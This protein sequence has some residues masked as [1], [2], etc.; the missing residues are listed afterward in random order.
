MNKSEALALLYSKKNIRLTASNW[1]EDEFIT[2]I[3]GVV[4]SLDGKAY[5]IMTAEEDEFIEWVEPI[6]V[7]TLKREEALQALFGGKRIKALEWDDS[8]NLILKDGQIVINDTE[9]FN[10]MT[11]NE[12]KWVVVVDE[13]E[14]NSKEINTL[15]EKVDKLIM[16]I[17]EQD[18]LLKKMENKDKVPES[19]AD[20]AISPKCEEETNEKIMAVYGVNNSNE[21]KILFADAIKS[22]K[23]KRDVQVAI[24]TAIPYCWIGKKLH[25]T[26][27]YY[28]NMRNIVKESCPEEYVD[29][30]LVLL[31]PPSREVTR[32]EKGVEVTT[33]VG[34]YEYLKDGEIQAGES[35]Y[36]DRDDYDLDM[37]EAVTSKLRDEIQ[38]ES[39]KVSR[40]DQVAGR[41]AMYVKATYLALVTGRRMSEILLS[42]KLK[43]KGGHWIYDG[44]LKKKDDKD[45]TGVA[46]TLDNDMEFLASLF[47]EVQE[48]VRISMDGKE[49]NEKTVASKFNRSCNNAFKKL[50]STN[51]TFKDA[52]EIFA[53]TLWRYEQEAREKEGLSEQGQ[54]AEEKF[55][56]MVLEHEYDNKKTPTLSYMTKRGVRNDK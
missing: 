26:K 16:K 5:N 42:V 53:D 8:V 38:N 18:T 47:D 52:R 19:D 27:L 21:V 34:L 44:L 31:T 36:D 40:Q 13:V 43:E 10:I 50:T 1:D 17:E 37:V 3:D 9:P 55:K 6:K 22:A 49:I 51:Y 7:E 39:Y 20:V 24:T 35:K 15:T 33:R 48:H 25:T 11:A 2:L 46:Y 45:R 32:M 28:S 29:M 12:D 14:N 56:A 54:I 4:V 41:S 23:N 30:A